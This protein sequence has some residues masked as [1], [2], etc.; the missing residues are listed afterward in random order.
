[1]VVCVLTGFLGSNVWL[2]VKGFCWPKEPLACVQA[3]L[4]G[5]RNW[6]KTCD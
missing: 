2:G 5:S 3:Y 4:F 6:N 1:M